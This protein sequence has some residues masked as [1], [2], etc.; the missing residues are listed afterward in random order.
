MHSLYRHEV[1]SSGL[2]DFLQTL[3]DG[4]ATGLR[5]PTQAA[6]AQSREPIDYLF[7]LHAVDL[8]PG[9]ELHGLAQLLTIAAPQVVNAPAPVYP[10]ERLVESPLWR[11]SDS[12]Q[13]WILTREN[14]QPRKIIQGPFDRDSF[15]FE[16]A[17]TPALVYETAHFPAVPLAPGY[18]G[19]DDYTPPAVVGSVVLEAR[20]LRWPWTDLQSFPSLRIA[21]TTNTRF[22]FYLRIRQTSAATRFAL[23]IPTDAWAAFP[24]VFAPED[25]LLKASQTT[26]AADT[27]QYWRCGGRIL[28]QSGKHLRDFEPGEAAAAPGC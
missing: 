20:D 13:Q 2:D 11:T 6:G 10:F 8:V 14:T 25:G 9:D 12:F 7:L 5:I 15:L 1:A 17:D 24:G 22:R 28:F 26:L 18:L 4:H 3:G 21:V 16:D 19:L 27:F 23:P